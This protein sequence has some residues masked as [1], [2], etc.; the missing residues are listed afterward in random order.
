MKLPAAP[1]LYT[2]RQRII[3]SASDTLNTDSVIPLQ[4]PWVLMIETDYV[5]MK[6]PAAPRAESGAR[7]LGFPFG[8]I[9][10]TSPSIEGVMRKMYPADR[11]PLAD[12]PNS[13]P[14]PVLMRWNELFK[15]SLVL[16]RCRRGA[17]V[18][19]SCSSG[20]EPICRHLTA[21]CAISVVHRMLQGKAEDTH[22]LPV[23]LAQVNASRHRDQCSKRLR[24]SCVSQLFNLLTP[25]AGCAADHAGLGA[26]HVAHRARQGDQ[27][28]AGLGAGDV[29]LVHWRRAAGKFAAATIHIY[30]YIL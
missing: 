10:P 5:W 15:V 6:P 17:G 3:S 8:Y 9:Q 7:S 14:A 19:S 25:P 12:V 21:V 13:G 22:M 2:H 30:T 27:G 29:R 24:T 20:C 28:A 23:P 11:G 4:A 16:H 26:A 1:R 18:V